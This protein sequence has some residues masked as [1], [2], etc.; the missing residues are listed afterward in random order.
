MISANDSLLATTEYSFTLTVYQ[1]IWI[2]NIDD[3]SIPH[4]NP[5]KTINFKE[6]LFNN[7]NGLITKATF[8]KD[9]GHP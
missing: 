1:Q 5:T 4:S 8:S 6:Y 3:F 9:N 2:K 7:G